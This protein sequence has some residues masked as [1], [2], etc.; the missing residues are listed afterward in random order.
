MPMRP[1]A[2]PWS[3]SVRLRRPAR[4]D[5]ALAR[6]VAVHRDVRRGVV[7]LAHR[8]AALRHSDLDPRPRPGPWAARTGSRRRPPAAYAGLEAV[9]HSFV[10]RYSRLASPRRI[11]ARP[12]PASSNA[13][14][15]SV[16]RPV[17]LLRP[18]TTNQ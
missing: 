18:G 12:Q 4:L 8:R 9:R 2:G 6:S 11:S 7:F 1:W 14:T 15:A 10:R 17:M 16:T 5:E 3:R 13:G